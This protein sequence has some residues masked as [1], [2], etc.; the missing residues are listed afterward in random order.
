MILFSALVIKT[1]QVVDFGHRYCQLSSIYARIWLMITSD[2]SACQ[3][4]PGQTV[5]QGTN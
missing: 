3:N 5:V 1:I 4:G 2:F